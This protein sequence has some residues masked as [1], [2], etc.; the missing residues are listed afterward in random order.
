MA[1]DSAAAMDGTTAMATEGVTVTMATAM[2]GTMA[3]RQQGTTQRL[4][5]GD[6]QQ[7]MAQAQHHGRRNDDSTV[8]NSGARR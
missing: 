2:N 3:P 1:M 7:G 5:N 6:G 4:L 8:M